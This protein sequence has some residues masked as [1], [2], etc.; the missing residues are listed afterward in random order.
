MRL[1]SLEIKNDVLKYFDPRAR[2][3]AGMA[4]VLTAVNLPNA[5]AP[6]ILTAVCVPL[7]R[8]DITRVAKRLVPLETFCVLFL[9]QAVC[10]LLK[11]YTAVIFILRINCAAFLYML[12]VIPMG[13][14]NVA[15]AL[16]AL[17]V[18]PKLVSILYLNYRYIYLMQ[19]TVLFAVKAMRLRGGEN[20]Q[21]RRK[22]SGYVVLIRYLTQG[23]YPWFRPKA[24]PRKR[25]LG[26]GPFATNQ[27]GLFLWKSYAAVFAAALAGAFDK[28]G[29]VT[30]ALNKR[31][32]DG[33]IPQ[34]AVWK[35]RA[36]DT[37]LTAGCS[38]LLALLLLWNI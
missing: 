10:G 31:G 35:W 20:Q 16:G 5:A 30:M 24:P 1:D 19:D 26:Y 32:F 2:L 8:R 28:A 38:L 3:I 25:A 21:P 7:L 34:T 12:T 33:S 17:K 27:K 15:Q 14:G 36:K 22:R 6:A 37:V 29:R 13:T 4:L 11:P 18:N 23:P 9:I